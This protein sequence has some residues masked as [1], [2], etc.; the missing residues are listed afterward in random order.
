MIFMDDRILDM[1]I[2][3]TLKLGVMLIANQ[4]GC[5]DIDIIG[6]GVDFNFNK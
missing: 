5:L 6:D 3:H 4:E 1:S 2:I